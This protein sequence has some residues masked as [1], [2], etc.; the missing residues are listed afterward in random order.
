VTNYWI[1]EVIRTIL[2]FSLA[3]G[4]GLLVLKKGVK[5]N[6]TRKVFHFALFFLP[7]YMAPVIPFEPSL[8]T[9]V[10]SG[11]VFMLCIALMAKPF[12][13]KS[14]FIATV[15]GKRT[16][17]TRALFTDRKYTRSIEGSACVFFSGILAIVLMQ[18]H[19]LV[20]YR[21]LQCSSCQ[22]CLFKNL[23]CDHLLWI[24]LNFQSQM[25]GQVKPCRQR[26]FTAAVPGDTISEADRN[27]TAG[28]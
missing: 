21:R 22:H 9:V 27:T 26:S 13:D 24:T 8:L 23:T 1:S 14:R 12:R 2:L 7:I 19:L 20:V 25:R 5:V 4:L 18:E 11:T 28:Q 6:Y 16:Y 17:Q 10:L 15:F 3:Y